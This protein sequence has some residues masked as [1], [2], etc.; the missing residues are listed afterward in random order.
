MQTMSYRQ[1]SL[2][3]KVSIWGGGKFLNMVEE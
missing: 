2:L 3:L 1:H